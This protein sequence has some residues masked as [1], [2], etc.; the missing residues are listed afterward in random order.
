MNR[1]DWNAIGVVDHSDV[2]V[3]IATKA[4]EASDVYPS[5]WFS[6][7]KR[8]YAA[9]PQFMCLCLPPEWLWSKMAPR[10]AHSMYERLRL[11]RHITGAAIVSEVR[12]VRIDA[13]WNDATVTEVMS[14]CPKCSMVIVE[15]VGHVTAE[16]LLQLLESCPMLARLEVEIDLAHGNG[17]PD[18]MLQRFIEGCPHIRS[19]NAADNQKITDSTLRVFATHCMHLKKISLARCAHITDIGLT[20]LAHGCNELQEMALE[21]CPIT[22]TTMRSLARYCH[23]LERVDLS[24]CDIPRDSVGVI[25]VKAFSPRCHIAL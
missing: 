3:Y 20:A 6:T 10:S 17:M 8:I 12:T 14:Y 15:N 4:F 11:Y 2:Y 23:H 16:R 9:Q 19:I 25:N 1:A 21:C 13:T 22:D 18:E 7:C 5:A 24:D